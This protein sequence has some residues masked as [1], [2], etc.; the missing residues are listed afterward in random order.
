MK[1]RVNC[2]YMCCTEDYITSR[3]IIA[4]HTD[5][6]DS[7]EKYWYEYQ[8]IHCFGKKNAFYSVGSKGRMPTLGFLIAV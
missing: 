3:K 2:V 6:K 5:F 8:T 7:R 1:L 4:K